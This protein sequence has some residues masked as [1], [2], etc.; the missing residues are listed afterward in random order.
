MYI[1]ISVVVPEP[2]Q[3]EQ[4]ISYILFITGFAYVLQTKSKVSNKTGIQINF[5]SHINC[6]RCSVE[7]IHFFNESSY[8]VCLAVS[9]HNIPMMTHSTITLLDSILT[10]REHSIM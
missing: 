1:Q 8:I 10:N 7:A 6:N 2:A 3:C 5:F 9:T 4:R